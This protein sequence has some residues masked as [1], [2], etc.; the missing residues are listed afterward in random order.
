MASRKSGLKT[1]TAHTAVR[2]IADARTLPKDAS[3][4]AKHVEELRKD[5]LFAALEQAIDWMAE[6]AEENVLKAATKSEPELRA[7]ASAL[8]MLRAV[9]GLPDGFALLAAEQAQIDKS[10]QKAT[11]NANGNQADE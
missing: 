4:I 3:L 11:E 10:I 5:W 9:Q 2:V 8:A 1:L 7:A 6:V